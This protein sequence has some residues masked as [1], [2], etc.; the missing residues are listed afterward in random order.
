[1]AFWTWLL[2]SGLLL[3]SYLMDGGPFGSD[4]RGVELWLVALGVLLVASSSG[5]SA[6]RRRC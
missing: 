3:A 2:G 1:M 6:W 5:S 4:A